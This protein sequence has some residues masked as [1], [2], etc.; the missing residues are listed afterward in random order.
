LADGA[1]GVHITAM[2]E[3]FRSLGHEV[4]IPHPPGAVESRRRQRLVEGFR[5]RLPQSAFE[6]ASVVYNAID[7]VR[8]RREIRRFRPDLL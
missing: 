7:S 6:L 4:R 1:E 3:A 5:A 8:F 2:V